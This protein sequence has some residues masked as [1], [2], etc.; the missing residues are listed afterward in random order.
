MDT[1]GGS[2][3]GRSK[4]DPVELLV[5]E[6]DPLQELFPPGTLGAD[7]MANPRHFSF[8]Q[9]VRILESGIPDAYRVGGTAPPAAERLRFR[10]FEGLGFPS[11]DIDRLE[12]GPE[13]SLD[14]RLPEAV[15][16]RPRITIVATF[17]GLHG[18]QSPLPAWITEEL[19][20]REPEDNPRRDFLD[21]FHHRLLSFLP[22][23]WE[24]YRYWARYRSGAQDPFSRRNFALIGL[25]DDDFRRRSVDLNWEKLLA[26][27]G[28]LAGRNRSGDVVR[29]VIAH[30]FDLPGRV[31][32]EEFVRRIVVIAQEQQNRLG[33]DNVR[34]GGD[35]HLGAQIADRSGKYRLWLGPLD[36]DRF[37]RFLPI[38]EDFWTLRRLVAFM[39][40]DQLAYDLCLTLRRHE[41]PPFRL[42][43][44]HCLLGWSTWIGEPPPEEP[45]TVTVTAYQ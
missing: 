13:G 3:F 34:L 26:Y 27:I 39:L 35:A 6:P 8:F 44:D 17:L 19:L 30:S 1:S 40:R 23:I 38:N 10:A 2:R 18:S 9:A 12:S 21:F 20:A 37:Y 28:L 45:Q 43:S 25:Y 15:R 24:K 33:R 5:D 32:V 42:S 11:S 14:H 29:G 16:R 41:V 7:L 36:F 22:R 4:S 31:K